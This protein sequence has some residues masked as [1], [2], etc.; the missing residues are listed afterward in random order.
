MGS[1]TKSPQTRPRFVDT[2]AAGGGW[3]SFPT[4][5]GMCARACTSKSAESASA[6]VGAAAVVEP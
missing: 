4:R 5:V 3:T 1:G 2:L 6:G